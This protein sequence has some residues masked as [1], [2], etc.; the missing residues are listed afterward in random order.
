MF[1]KYASVTSIATA[2][3]ENDG[4]RRVAAKSADAAPPT[5]NLASFYLDG[6][7]K[8][9]VRG[10]LA[11][12]ADKYNLSADPAD[13]IFEAIRANTVNV[14]NENHDG[15]HRN[16]LLRF[17]VRYASP[18]GDRVGAP[19]YLTYVGKPHHLNHK[20]DD[21]KRARGVILDAHYN[22]ST[23]A[24]AECGLCK[25]AT[26]D[27]AGRDASG[28]HCKK[29][30]SV[31]KDEFVEILVAVDTKKDPALARGIQAGVLNAGSMGCNCASTVC[32]VCN[33]VARSV[34]EFC[35]HIR[36]ASKGSLWMRKGEKFERTTREDVMNMLRRAGYQLGPA[37]DFTVGVS[38]F[39]PDNEFEVRKAFEYCQGVEFDEY[40][41]VHRPAD[42]KA[43][44]VEILKAAGLEELP[45][46]IEQETEQLITRARL[47]QLETMPKS[48]SKPETFYAIRVNANDEDIHVAS[49]VK[50]AVKLAQLG[51]RDKAEYFTVEAPSLSAAV[52]NAARATLGKTAQYLPLDADVQLVVPD[53]M[54][55]H[56]DPAGNVTQSPTQ[57]GME[58]IPPGAPGAPGRPTSIEDVTQDEVGPEDSEQSPEEFGML[59]PGASAPLD[60][61]AEGELQSPSSVPKEKGWT[62]D[63]QPSPKPKQTYSQPTSTPQE[64]G[65]T[66]EAN[67]FAAVYGDFECE[68]FPQHAIL[69]APGCDILTVKSAETL[70]GPEAKRKFGRALVDS[71]LSQGI[72]RTAMKFKA[73]VTEGAMF[74]MAEKPAMSGGGILE[75]AV[76]DMKSMPSGPKKA[77]KSVEGPQDDMKDPLN[78]IPPS[79]I[80]SRE[81]DMKEEAKTHDAKDSTKEDDDDMKDTRPQHTHKQDALEG[82][83]VDMKA[84]KAALDQAKKAEE[85][86]RKLYASRLE[87]AKAEFEAERQILEKRVI[88]RVARVL[89]LAAKR[90][91]LNLEVSPLKA[92]VLDS[93]TVSRA[94]GRNASTNEAIE[95]P[96]MTDDLALH[97]IEAA[98]NESH[99]EEIDSLMSR[100]AELLSYDDKYLASAEGDLSKQAA[101]VPPIVV[102]AQV[103]GLDEIAERAASLRKSAA[104]GNLLFA[105]STPDATVSGDR[106]TSI[107]EALGPTRISRMLTEEFRPN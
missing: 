54:Q 2:T 92:K 5:S 26:S 83:D 3:F 64:K 44:T 24:L 18:F 4:L 79:V 45:L 88:D 33:H 72:V 25:N 20:T 27:E 16:E 23:P 78:P 82:A 80:E 89:K 11:K 71:L 49:S 51:R 52:M 47:A 57:P 7:R 35:D 70:D 95:Y 42:P 86:V 8:L 50:E 9:D 37:S 101:I 61:T 75:G 29:C 63:E 84:K 68:V 41:R 96:G 10:M 31:V 60:A 1:K 106:S 43:R 46:T 62:M 59:P 74:S 81:T 22:D 17:D 38:L 32:N 94:V 73:D 56:V 39:G 21:P 28:I 19:V 77:P 36:G 58:Q 104:S 30:G 100:A 97:L 91:A 48:A 69:R 40:S 66:L 93:L 87:K 99:A 12:A 15:F 13:Y 6:S 98:W 90:R 14:P 105:P 76:N 85:R 55:V 107:R 102:S 34:Q 53:G 67:K 65:W 103:E